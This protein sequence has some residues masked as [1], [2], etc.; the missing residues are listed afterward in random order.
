MELIMP[1]TKVILAQYQKTILV[2][3]RIQEAI[4]FLKSKSIKE[5]K[6]RFFKQTAYCAKQ[7]IKYYNQVIHK[8]LKTILYI[9]KFVNQSRLLLFR[10]FVKYKIFLKNKRL[11]GHSLTWS[12]FRFE[13]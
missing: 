6:T 11:K 10:K 3:A 8:F 1:I 13:A 9:K 2:K 7:V 5:K 12:Q 4:N